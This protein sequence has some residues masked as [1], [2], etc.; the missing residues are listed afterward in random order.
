MDSNFLF[1]VGLI[2]GTTILLLVSISWIDLFTELRNKYP[3]F[4]NPLVGQL[5]YTL[6]FTIIGIIFL[7]VFKPFNTDSK[8]PEG[9]EKARIEEATLRPIDLLRDIPLK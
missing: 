3:A 5:V 6:S 4:K 9:I 2:L 1:Q 8:T 7:M